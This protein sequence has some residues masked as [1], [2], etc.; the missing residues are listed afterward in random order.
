[1]LQNP[2]RNILFGKLDTFLL[3]NEE[4]ADVHTRRAGFFRDHFS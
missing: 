2:E 1:V 3:E 4:L